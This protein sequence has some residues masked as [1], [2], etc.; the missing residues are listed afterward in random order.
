M[1]Y[2]T[3]AQVKEYLGIT[4][5]SED[6]LLTRLLDAATEMIARHCER[7]FEAVNA[8]KVVRREQ[9][10]LGV[11]FL[12]DDLLSLTQVV[13][14]KGD[15]LLPAHFQPLAAPAR[16]LRLRHDAPG[17]SMDYS[18]DVTGTWGYSTTPPKDI[19]QA[20]VRLAGWLY[21]QKDAQTF[22]LIGEAGLNQ[23]S[24][25]SS[26]PRDILQQLEPYLVRRMIAW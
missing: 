22:D 23:A 14:D 13:T 1:A 11:F 20:C 16:L 12:P 15:T 26:V 7:S 3:L 9:Y 24:V 4:G 18:V 21:R 19:E 25:Q 17:W 10:A 6:A 8:T 5:T 2:A